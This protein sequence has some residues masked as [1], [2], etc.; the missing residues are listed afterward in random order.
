MSRKWMSMIAL[1]AFAVAPVAQAEV[2]GTVGATTGDLG[3]V[4]VVRDG[5]VYSLSTG[6]T[7][8]VGDIVATRSAGSVLL[9]LTGCNVSLGGVE[10][11]E[12]GAASCLQGAVTSASVAA[13]TTTTVAATTAPLLLSAAGLATL[14][15]LAAGGDDDGGD[16]PVSP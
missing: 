10:Q 5:E 7:L 4:L 9:S 6:D 13:A 3:S 12:I 16:L 11:I 8:L 15:A 1:A 2:A 14:G